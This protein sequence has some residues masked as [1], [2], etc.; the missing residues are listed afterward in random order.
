MI[1]E[2]E[3]YFPILIKLIKRVYKKRYR[4]KY[5]RKK[6]GRIRQD[7]NR[8]CNIIFLFERCIGFGV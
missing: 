7:N 5:K 2:T 8:F 4:G 6:K 1:K 3:E